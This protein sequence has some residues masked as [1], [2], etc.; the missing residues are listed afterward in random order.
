MRR[1]RRVLLTALVAVAATS[2]APEPALA[3]CTEEYESC[4]IA[5]WQKSNRLMRELKFIECFATFVGCVR[6]ELG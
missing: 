4:Q 2:L 6:G 3:G 1:G 5:G